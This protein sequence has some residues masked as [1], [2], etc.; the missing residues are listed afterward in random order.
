MSHTLYLMAF[1]SRVLCPIASCLLPALRACRP[2]RPLLGRVEG[3]WCVVACL[4]ALRHL[5]CLC[6]L[7]GTAGWPVV[8]LSSLDRRLRVRPGVGKGFSLIDRASA[9]SLTPASADPATLRSPVEVGCGGCDG[10]I[11]AELGGCGVS[12]AAPLCA[13]LAC[14]GLCWSAR[15]CDVVWRAVLRGAVQRCA[16]LCGAASGCDGRC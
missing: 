5:A 6:R 15:R 8:L 3:S 14:A 9:P 16:V 13:E 12:C 1:E 2:C 11:C 10:L 7:D 4:C